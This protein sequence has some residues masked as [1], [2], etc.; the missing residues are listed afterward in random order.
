MR[1]NASLVKQLRTEKSWTQQHLADACGISLR[2]VQRVERYGTASNETLMA[3]S[4]VFEVT[5]VEIQ[6][7]EVLAQV[8][9]VDKMKNKGKL[10]VSAEIVLSMCIGFVAGA[11]VTLIV[12]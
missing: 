2:T 1:V 5:Q 11:V 7:P 10:F 9:P 4:A 6:E 12:R 8:M 3:L